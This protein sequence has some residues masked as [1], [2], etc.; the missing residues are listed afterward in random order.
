MHLFFHQLNNKL[1]ICAQH[2]VRVIILVRFYEKKKSIVERHWSCFKK[3]V[4]FDVLAAF[5]K[6]N[7]LEKDY[8][9]YKKYG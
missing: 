5:P 3:L 6:L 8:I 4:E 2:T 1:S 9:N 7:C